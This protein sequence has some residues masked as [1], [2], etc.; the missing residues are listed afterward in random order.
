[1]TCSCVSLAGYAVLAFLAYKLFTTLYNII[2]PY[3]FAVPQN[4]A[5]LAGAKWAVVT[6]STDGIGKAYAFELA[7]KNFNLVLISRSIDKLNEVSKE[8]TQ[9]FDHIQVKTIA[10]DFTNTNLADYEATIFSVLGELEVGLL[11][12]L[13][14]IPHF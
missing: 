1:M 4:I 5:V 2:F 6:G 7:K 10:F 9:K 11:G 8:I 14:D 13:L 3:L 12:R